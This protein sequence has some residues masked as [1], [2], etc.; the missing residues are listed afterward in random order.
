MSR[1]WWLSL[2]ATSRTPACASAATVRGVGHSH[3]SFTSTRASARTAAA[4]TSFSSAAGTCSSSRPILGS[5]LNRCASRPRRVPPRAPVIA[6]TSP[7]ITS[8][9]VSLP[10][11]SAARITAG[12]TGPSRPGN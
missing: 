3:F 4:A 1:Q 11:Q 8:A 10:S 2:P 6:V 7:S 9:A 12:W 5:R